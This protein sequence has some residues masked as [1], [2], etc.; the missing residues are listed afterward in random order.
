MLFI[1]VASVFFAQWEDEE[2]EEVVIEET[3][4]K[5]EIDYTLEND[6]ACR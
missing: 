5:G 3:R 2:G 4:S 6:E 1:L